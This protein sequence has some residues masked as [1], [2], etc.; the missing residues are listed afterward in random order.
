MMRYDPK[1]CLSTKLEEQT[2]SSSRLV[3]P[4]PRGS[5]QEK[6]ELRQ[7]PSPLR[8]RH[9][10]TASQGGKLV[11][12]QHT[13]AQQTQPFSAPTTRLALCLLALPATCVMH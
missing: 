5:W 4:R 9:R 8:P 11:L 12:S 6:P 1:S 13:P 10:G 7:P 2:F 3:P